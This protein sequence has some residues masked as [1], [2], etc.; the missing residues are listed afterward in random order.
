[1]ID[2]TDLKRRIDLAALIESDLGP[3]V[4]RAGR[5]LFWRCPFH[6]DI[7]PSLAVTPDTGTWHC[8]GCG[9]SGDVI[10]WLRERE[11]LTFREAC[12][13][14]GV[15]DILDTPRP[16]P[17]AEDRSPDPAWQ[18]RAREI[19]DAT[20]AA[21]WGD[22]GR[23]ARDWLHG[24]GLRD[25]ALKTWGIGYNPADRRIAGL[26]VP[27]G[28]VIPCLVDGAVQ[29]LKVRRPAPPL[30]GPKYRQVKGG[31]GALFG[32]DHLT[33]KSTVV[34]C[35]GEFDAIL[36]WQEAGDLV[37]VVATGG[38]NVRPAVRFLGRLLAARRWLVATDRDEAGDKG[39][40]WW[41]D[42]SA[43]VR[44]VRPL[45][46]RDLTDF[47]QAGGDLRAWVAHHL[48]QE[49]AERPA[50]TAPDGIWADPLVRWAVEKLGAEVING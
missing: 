46:G 13:R 42:F 49:E 3:P 40:E 32:L 16:A 47:H 33:G 8:F 39:A 18:A 23:K 5:W 6:A 43:R 1:M 12:E 45:E 15:Q 10:T 9:K 24:R 48:K 41:S 38:A 30:P 19:V 7:H 35:E 28:I 31:V 29:Y 37:D 44:R 17:P 11:G 14:L 22:A 20:V 2:T 36:L 4:S 21:L 26:Y 50:A 25:E 27:R 34:I